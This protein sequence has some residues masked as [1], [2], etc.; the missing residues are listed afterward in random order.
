MKLQV[1]ERVKIE[2]LSIRSSFLN[3]DV[4]LSIILPP[5]Y[6]QKP[7]PVLWLNDG[8]DMSAMQ[9]NRIL[10]DLYTQEVVKPMI[11]VG[12]HANEDRL[13]EYGSSAAADFKNRGAKAGLYAEFL[14]N[15]LLPFIRNKY[16][17]SRDKRKN[18]IAGWSMGGLSAIDIAWHFSNYFGKVGVFSGSL[19]WRLK[20]Y[21]RG[22]KDD[23]HRIIHQL[24]RNTPKR[25]GLRFWFEC[26]T[27]DEN[28]DRNKNGLIDSIDDTIDFIQELKQKGYNEQHDIQFVIV[29]DGEH[30]QQT[31]AEIMPYFLTWAFGA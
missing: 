6:E 12:I 4:Q 15:E 16:S 24:I 13:Q 2:S 30:N 9:F 8:Q 22:Y 29:K 7:Y 11:V 23:K 31:W 25:E 20:A 5:A 27:N 18:V 26:G 1:P 17:V 21:N 14:V 28:A 19:W 10:D 3:R